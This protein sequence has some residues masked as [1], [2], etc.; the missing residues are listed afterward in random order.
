MQK[1]V[2]ELNTA[3]KSGNLETIKIAFGE[4]GKSCKACHDN[5]RKK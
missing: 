3:A 5:Y 4:A 2:A 1:A